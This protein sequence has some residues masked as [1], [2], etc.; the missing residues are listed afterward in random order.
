MMKKKQKRKVFIVFYVV[1]FIV[2]LSSGRIFWEYTDSN[3]VKAN[4]TDGK[5]R[6]K[7]VEDIMSLSG[8]REFYPRVFLQRDE[9]TSEQTSARKIIHVP[10]GGTVY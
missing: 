7:H 8:E 5:L 1:L 3:S 2:I 9:A 10:Y 6:V 4:L